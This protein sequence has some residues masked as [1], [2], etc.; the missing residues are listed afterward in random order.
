MKITLNKQRVIQLSN[1]ELGNLRGGEDL[2]DDTLYTPEGQHRSNHRT[3]NCN[4]SRAHPVTK[5]FYDGTI[6][7]AGQNDPIGTSTIVVGCN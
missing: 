6:P 5:E 3:G 7:P 1:I 2:M 4:Y